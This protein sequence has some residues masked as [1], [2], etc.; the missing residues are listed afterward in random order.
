VS[1]LLRQELAEIIGERTL[2]ITDRQKLARSIAAYLA[3]ERRH[4]D[5]SSLMRDVMQYRIDHGII[6]AVAVSAHELNDT[7]IKDVKDLLKDHFP[8]A[9][10]ILVDTRID[11]TV[12]GGIRIELP[13]ENLDLSVKAKLNLFKR[14]VAE[15][16]N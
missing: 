3:A 16:R 8:H 13:R 2:H 12:V 15:E 4:V 11:E 14:L 6:E 1:T 10:K 5:L 7:V 9:K